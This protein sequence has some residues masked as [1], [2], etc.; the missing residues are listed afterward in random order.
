MR[1][2]IQS[3][4]TL[5]AKMILPRNDAPVMIC[6]HGLMSS[7][8][9]SKIQLLMAALEKQ[10]IGSLAFDFFAHGES[11]GD[12]EDL[13]LTKGIQN[14]KDVVAFAK[15]KTSGK[16]LLYGSS[17]GGAAAYYASIDVP[18]VLVCPAIYYYEKELAKGKEYIEKWKKQGFI[19]RKNWEGKEFKQGF[20]FFEDLQQYH[21]NKHITSPVL[22]LHGDADD[23]VPVQ[24]SVKAA[25]TLRNTQLMVF[26]N[27]NHNFSDTGDRDALI[28]A[29]IDFALDNHA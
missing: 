29:T 25:K 2:Q 27:A 10:G 14:V 18:M 22:F 28:Q 12:F 9:S 1:M 8:E 11:G 4:T 13:T 26:P 7:K 15:K 6:C 19:T 16:I 24:D 3:N 23:I 17:F 5:A 21:G 20:Q